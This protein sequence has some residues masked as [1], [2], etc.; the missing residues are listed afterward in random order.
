MHKRKRNAA[1]AA[2]ASLRMVKMTPEERSRI[3]RIAGKAA[4][5]VHRAKAIA[6]R[7]AARL[8]ATEEPE[9]V[10]A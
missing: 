5:K 1:A 6:R 10:S 2:L 3:A 7:K 8:A 9:E 4:G